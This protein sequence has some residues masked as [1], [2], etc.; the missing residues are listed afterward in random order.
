MKRW[1]T[2]AELLPGMW[3]K[4]ITLILLLL[5]CGIC[6]GDNQCPELVGRWPYGRSETVTVADS[7]AYYGNGA[8]LMV[9]DISDPTS[10]QAV[11]EISFPDAIRG[12]TIS[13]SFAYVSI[14]SYGLRIVDISTPSAPSEVGHYIGWFARSTVVSGTYAYLTNGSSGLKILDVSS[15]AA[16]TEVGSCDTD[17]NVHDVAVLGDY[18]YLADFSGMRVIDI[19][20]PAAPSVVAFLETPDITR[21]IAV[22]GSYAYLAADDALRVVSIA[23]PSTP[24]EVGSHDP[25]G[26]VYDVTRSVTAG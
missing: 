16:P 1:L 22:S 15:P 8:V 19:S 4:R 2:G 12:V 5:G 23:N 3:Q 18:A 24:I 10:P 21:N 6:S 26:N 13:G 20:T 25:Q 9:A 7:L 11:G 17:G 14:G